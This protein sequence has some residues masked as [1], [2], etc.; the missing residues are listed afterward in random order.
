MT[1]SQLYDVFLKCKGVSTDTRTIS[2]G[3]LFFSLKGDNFDGNQYA[4]KA[5]EKG[6]KYAVI[7]DETINNPNFIKVK[8]VLSSLQKLAKHHRLQLNN[9]KFIAITGSNGKTTTKELIKAVLAKNYVTTSTKG[10]L[11]NHIGV[12][13]ALLGITENSKFAIIEMGANHIGEI[14]FL[15]NLIN[16]D[17]GYI[18]NFGKAHLEGF[19]GIKGVIKGK[20]EL[21]NWLLKNNK[22]ILINVDDENQKKYIDSNSITFG[23]NN[24][25]QFVFNLEIPKSFI[26]LSYKNTLINTRLVGSYNFSNIQAAISIGLYFKMDIKLIKDAIE[27]YIPKNNRSEI[28]ELNNKKIILDAYNANPSSM[29]LAI[30]SFLKYPESKIFILGDMFELGKF[31]KTEHQMVINKLDKAQSKAY[32]VGDEFYKLKKEYNNLFFFKTKNELFYEMK[33]NKIK[34]KNILIKGSRG[35]KMEEILEKI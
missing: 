22:P 21:Y 19:G 34:E 9:T 23:L 18:T 35:M 14:D 31:S 29:E 24:N 25:A 2:K 11:N 27:N 5:I 33:K 17:F 20:S 13:L 10:N 7:D 4:L 30:D 8:N 12:P 15:T 3:N 16:P 6:A 1:T 26:S 28:I 32:F